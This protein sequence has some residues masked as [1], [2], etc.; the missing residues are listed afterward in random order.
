MTNFVTNILE[1]TQDFL[2]YTDA[3]FRKSFKVAAPPP[4]AETTTLTIDCQYQ[5]SH[6]PRNF[7]EYQKD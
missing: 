5:R 4:I 6:K 2:D 1:T 3:F 7:R